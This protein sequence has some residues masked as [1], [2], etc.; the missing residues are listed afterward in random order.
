MGAMTST[1]SPA[2]I[3]GT[4]PDS[5]SDNTKDDESPASDVSGAEAEPSTEKVSTEKVSSEKVGSEQAGTGST[6]P[7]RRSKVIARR[8]LRGLPALRVGALLSVVGAVILYLT[9]GSGVRVISFDPR[10]LM[11]SPILGIPA[12]WILSTL[13]RP[14][15]LRFRDT[16]GGPSFAALSAVLAVPAIGGIMACSTWAIWR[17]LSAWSS[18]LAHTGVNTGELIAIAAGTAGLA[19]LAIFDILIH[20]LRAATL[21]PE[22]LK[23]KR[24]RKHRPRRMMPALRPQGPKRRTL[25]RAALVLTPS[26]ILGGAAA[27]PLSRR[28]DAAQRLAAAPEPGSLPAYPSSL[29]GEQAW[30]RDVNNMLDIVAGAAGPVVHTSDGVIGINPSDGSTLWSYGLTGATYLRIHCNLPNEMGEKRLRTLVIS[31]DQRHVAFRIADPGGPGP[32]GD[33][34]QKT[35][36]I[37]L[38]ATTGQVVNKHFS[39]SSAIL[40]LTDSALLD[41]SKIYSLGSD[42]ETWEFDDDDTTALAPDNEYSGTAGHATFIVYI[43]TDSEQSLGDD[44]TWY[45]RL[46]LVPQDDPGHVHTPPPLPLAAGTSSVIVVNGWTAIYSDGAP[47]TTNGSYDQGWTMQAVSLDALTE[48][49]GPKDQQRHNLGRGVGI[50]TAAS[51]ATGKI[52][53]L[54]APAPE[55][56]R[57]GREPDSFNWDDSPTTSVIFNPS[58][59]EAMAVDQ[60]T[61]LIRALGITPPTS[62]DNPEARLRALP[63]GRG[64]E[65]SFPISPGSVFHTPGSRQYNPELR[66]L[67]TVVSKRHSELSTLHAPGVNLIILNPTPRESDLPHTYRL[68]GV[69]ETEPK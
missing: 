21:P 33:I 24:E 35:A 47:T 20:T 57:G 13:F 36:T 26:I 8:L 65:V 2:D 15:S 39:Y 11:R 1:S 38:D 59:Q 18:I 48:Q 63:M 61:G 32:L 40:Q 25:A 9:W 55:E 46:S 29:A 16:E 23:K 41:G 19:L 31:P 28:K 6:G 27:I 69:L 44:S 50:N 10:D 60:A 64:Q 58:T 3:D 17:C 37:V 34:S 5:I 66:E 30:T 14:L 12:F 62:P 4:S 68:F 42:I 54:P 7:E 56:V 43:E 51:I 22:L 49:G 67:A 45:A 53:T 52:I